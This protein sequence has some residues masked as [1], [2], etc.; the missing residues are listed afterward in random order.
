MRSRQDLRFLI[1]GLRSIS[2]NGKQVSLAVIMQ[3]SPSPIGLDKVMNTVDDGY[4]RV[5]E[6]YIKLETKSTVHDA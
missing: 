2:A 1:E 3:G 5:F 6:D 4:H